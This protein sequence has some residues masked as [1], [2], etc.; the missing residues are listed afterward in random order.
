MVSI[1][2]DAGHG[3]NDPGA[4]GNGLKEKDLNLTITLAVGKILADNGVKVFYTRTSDVFLELSDRAKKANAQKVDYFVSFHINSA[5]G[6]NGT[7]FESFTYSGNNAS[8]KDFQNK[9]HTET[10]KHL[11]E[12][13]VKDRGQKKAAYA[14]LEK[15]TMHAVLIENLFI[16]NPTDAGL[17]KNKLT[18]IIKAN[19]YGIL[20]GLGITPKNTGV[21]TPTPNTS[22]KG[23]RVQVGY[24]E[25]KANAE[26]LAEE[27]KK[28]GYPAIIKED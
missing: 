7:G 8:T 2:L 13:K 14:V 27:L 17:L 10:M 20:K 3:G 16:N 6:T 11:T 24:F 25:N 15:T 18:T 21:S 28:K 12:L 4:V 26:K 1:M 23:Y 22:K 5:S 19:A 9:L